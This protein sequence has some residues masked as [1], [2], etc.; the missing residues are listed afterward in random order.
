MGERR[1]DTSRGRPRPPE[2]PSPA[3]GPRPSRIR[4]ALRRSPTSTLP[5]QGTLRWSFTWA[6]EGIVYVLHTQRNMQ[7]HVGAAVVTAGHEALL[8]FSR[9]EL[10]AIMG[11][12]RPRA[13]GGD[14]E[15][16][17]RGGDRRAVSHL[18]PPLVK[19]AKDVA[20]GA[21]L[22]ATV[23]ALAI[24]ASSSTTS[25]TEPGRDLLVGVRRSPAH[26]SRGADRDAHHDRRGE[27]VGG[28]QH[29]PAGS[30]PSGHAAAAFAGWAAVT[31]IADPCATRRSCPRSP[32]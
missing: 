4:R 7:I 16:R 12:D 19:I 24:A 8:D 21:V 2:S 11:A 15:H 14:D 10:A 5:P 17:R 32:S 6:F 29:A 9:L 22:V 27:G 3:P 13:G 1:G 30:L 28:A 26:R 23:N 25:S 20:A 18:V 31:I